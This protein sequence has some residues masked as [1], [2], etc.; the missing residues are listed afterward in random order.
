[1]A[2]F[3]APRGNDLIAFDI[4]CI[5]RETDKAILV[6]TAAIGRFGGCGGTTDFWM[7]KSQIEIGR[8]YIFCKAWI[9]DAK[10]RET[11]ATIMFINVETARS[12]EADLAKRAA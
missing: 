11:G 3:T 4:V 8:G 2:K 12:A 5:V 10:R 1:M 9:A 7:P 6:R